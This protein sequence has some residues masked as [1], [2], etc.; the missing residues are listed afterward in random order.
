MSVEEGAADVDVH[1]E[2][3]KDG[4]AD[5]EGEGEPAKLEFDRVLRFTEDN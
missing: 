3:V 4:R 5:V 1:G 2:A